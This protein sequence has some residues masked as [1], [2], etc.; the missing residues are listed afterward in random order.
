MRQVILCRM[1]RNQKKFSQIAKF[2][3]WVE[4]SDAHQ[5]FNMELVRMELS[6]QIKKAANAAF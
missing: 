4:H 5:S 1:S 3:G 6:P 2:A